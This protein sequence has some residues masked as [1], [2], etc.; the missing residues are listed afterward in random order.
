[1]WQE[2]HAR[3]FTVVKVTRPDIPEDI[4]RALQQYC[5]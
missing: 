4:L 5:R 1:M 3:A 2:A